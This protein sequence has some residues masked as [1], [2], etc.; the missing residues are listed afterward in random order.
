MILIS[1]AHRLG[2]VASLLALATS[3]LI[4]RGTTSSQHI[5]S[6]HISLSHFP[7]GTALE[8]MSGQARDDPPQ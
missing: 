2:A 8:A 3:A 6:T 5:L 1:S 4:P 7:F